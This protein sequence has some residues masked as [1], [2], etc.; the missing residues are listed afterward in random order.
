MTVRLLPRVWAR[1]FSLCVVAMACSWVL[2]AGDGDAKRRSALQKEQARIAKIRA[3][4]RKKGA[5]PLQLMALVY[6]PVA[7]GNEKQYPKTI[8][9]ANRWYERAEEAEKKREPKK[10]KL[11]EGLAG[12]FKAYAKENKKVVE[13]YKK[14]NT[15]LVRKACG[16][17]VKIERRIFELTGERVDRDW[18]TPDELLSAP[19]TTPGTDAGKGGRGARA[20]R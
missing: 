19:A 18:F 16:Q 11:Y 12:L 13:A 2:A 6:E 14:G 8:R 15:A 4:A 9:L 17:I 10:A 3:W 20:E 5:S 1:A 7:K